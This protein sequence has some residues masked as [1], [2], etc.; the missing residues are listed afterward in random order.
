MPSLWLTILKWVGLAAAVVALIGVP[1]VYMDH[2]VKAA[3]EQ[4]VEAGKEAE[5]ARI[6]ELMQKQEEYNTRMTKD[7]FDMA[8]Q[9]NEQNAQLQRKVGSLQ[10]KLEAALSKESDCPLGDE[11][12]R[13]LRSAAAGVFSPEQDAS[14]ASGPAGKVPDSISIP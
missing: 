8:K 4:G 5:L 6:N 12:S 14:L 2:K 11:S 3:Y 10:K 1:V 7:E 9:R 13:L